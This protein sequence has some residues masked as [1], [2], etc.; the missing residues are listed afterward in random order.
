MRRS[1][2]RSGGVLRGA[3]LVGI[4]LEHARQLGLGGRG[5]LGE[6]RGRRLDEADDLAAQLVERRQVSSERT[7]L[8]SL[9]KAAATFGA[10]TGS[11]E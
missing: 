10:A 11:S 2:G 6:L 4:G 1:D 3:I 7:P 5:E 9:A 8:K